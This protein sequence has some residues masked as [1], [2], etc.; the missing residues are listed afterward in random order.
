MDKIAVIN[1]YPYHVR[2]V[3]EGNP[4]WVFF[5]GFMGSYAEFEQ[6]DPQGTRIYIDLLGFGNQAPVVADAPRFS[7]EN[8][9]KDLVALFDLFDLHDIRL[10]GYSM[11]AR[12]ALAFAMM[13]P[14]YVAH[15]YLESGTAGLAEIDARQARVAADAEK[16][17]RIE[18]DGMAKFVADWEQLPLFASQQRLSLTQ[19]Q[20]MHEQRVNQMAANVANSLRYF[21]TGAMPNYWDDLATLLVPVTLITGENDQKF[22]RLNA[23]M[24]TRLPN[25]RR[26]I[27]PG[28]GHNVH[29]ENGAAVVAALQAEV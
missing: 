22:D 11:G 2:I 16:A 6:I 15:L 13:Q 18:T 21:G 28:A 14:A 20:F 7:A 26:V 8:Q 9:V 17:Q 12:L 29:F 1:D 19:Q 25:V 4:T 23:D 3:G 10:V 24:A 5:H 27:V